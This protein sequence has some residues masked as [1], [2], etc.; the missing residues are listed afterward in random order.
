MGSETVGNIV[1]GGSVGRE[2]CGWC[3]RAETV[4]IGAFDGGKVTP[5]VKEVVLATSEMRIVF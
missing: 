5:V 4:G 3:V 2:V 1:I